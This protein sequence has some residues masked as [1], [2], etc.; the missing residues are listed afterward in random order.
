MNA[1]EV[2]QCVARGVVFGG[3]GKLLLGGGTGELCN[4]DMGSI[5]LIWA[6]R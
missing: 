3:G 6:P 5:Y 1:E 2:G 4:G